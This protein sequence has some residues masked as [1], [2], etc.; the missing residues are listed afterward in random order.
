MSFNIAGA[1]T[2]PFETDGIGFNGKNPCCVI[3]AGKEE[4][5]VRISL[6][7]SGAAKRKY[8]DRCFTGDIAEQ[9]YTEQQGDYGFTWRV[10]FLAGLRGIRIGASFENRSAEPVR[11]KE[12]H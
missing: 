6:E 7:T 9:V 10:G 8:Y 3:L 4:K 2:A 12:F 11:L 1:V 5:P